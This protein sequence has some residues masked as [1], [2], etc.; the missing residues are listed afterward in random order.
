MKVYA[1][2]TSVGVVPTLVTMGVIYFLFMMFGVFTVRVP[3]PD[4]KP[5]GF[6]ASSSQPQKLV[7]NAHVTA[8]NAWK[9]PSFWLLWVILCFNV[10]AGI[11]ILEQASPMIQEMLL[12]PNATRGID[13]ADTAAI[14]HATA[15]LAAIAGGFDVRLYRA[16][17]YLL[18]LPA[19][20]AGPL[21][22]HSGG[23]ADGKHA[24]FRGHL[25]R[26]S[27][28]VWGRLRRDSRLPA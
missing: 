22:S 14:A 24:A 15:P 19:A 26:D 20:R 16:Q 8:D 12:V 21:L 1:T 27:Q 3:A 4:W 2:P 7:T 9:T 28:H 25:R 13:P 11:G 5:A 17:E 10:T 18:Y 6:V 23:R